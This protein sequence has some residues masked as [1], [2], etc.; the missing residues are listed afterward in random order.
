M[1]N[2]VNCRANNGHYNSGA[3]MDLDEPHR[4]KEDFFALLNQLE[5]DTNSGLFVM[6][7]AVLKEIGEEYA[8]VRT[9]R[10]VIPSEQVPQLQL[11]K[12]A[13]EVEKVFMGA[14]L[15]HWKN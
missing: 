15:R 9:K 7:G 1:L 12:T 13:E 2:I 6:G 8:K 10:L 11:Q 4:V 14:F 3:D 5:Y